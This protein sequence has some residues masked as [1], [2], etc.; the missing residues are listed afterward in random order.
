MADRLT[1]RYQPV[2]PVICG[3]TGSGK[4]A[5]AMRLARSHSIE[6]V[7][8][9][10]RQII[11]HLIIGASKPSLDDQKQVVHHLLNL[12]EPGERYSAFKFLVNAN[13]AIAEILQKGK[14]PIIVGGTGLYIKALT[15][16]IVEMDNQDPKIR[17]CL[18][19]EMEEIGPEAMHAR[20]ERID[21][22]AAA[23]IHP[24]NRPRVI[25]ALEI[26]EQTG[27]PKSE[28]ARE[29]RYHQSPYEFK[30]FALN[31]PREAV[32]DAI[33]SRVDE[34]FAAGVLEELKGLIDRGLSEKI[35][36]SKVICY[37]ELLEYV[38]G[39][40]TLQEA[41]DLIKQNTRRYA[42]R[43]VTWLRHQMDAVTG[44]DTD[45]LYHLVDA[46]LRRSGGAN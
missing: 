27:K 4:S 18:E 25:R 22:E 24:N 7:S 23:M 32:Y 41:V 45:S 43:Q 39:T 3:P 15:D 21:S 31:P 30:L 35:R 9:D 37:T 44:F 36:S 26:Y 13:N 8:A 2:I 16:G 6:I 28:L 34:M 1:D 46:Y 19:K 29:G 20:L 40:M 5:V 38:K 10:S 11:R 17:D 33:N 12:I 14:M 42:K